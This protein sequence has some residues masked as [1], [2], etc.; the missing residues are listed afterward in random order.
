MHG[1]RELNAKYV[2]YCTASN[3]QFYTLSATKPREPTYALVVL[4]SAHVAEGVLHFMMNKVHRLAASDVEATKKH[5]RKLWSL[6]KKNG[7]LQ[8]SA[9]SQK[10]DASSPCTP[11]EAKRTRRLCQTPTDASIE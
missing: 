4:G 1:D 8:S 9:A 3:V 2:S 6:C 7:A 11:F 10:R 5:C